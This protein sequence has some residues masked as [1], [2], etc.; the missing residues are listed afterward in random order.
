[1]PIPKYLHQKICLHAK[2]KLGIPPYILATWLRSLQHISRLHN[3]FIYP[4]LNCNSFQLINTTST[5]RGTLP[6]PLYI[7][8]N[9][10]LQELSQV[11]LTCFLRNSGMAKNHGILGNYSG[12]NLQSLMWVLMVDDKVVSH[13]HYIMVTV[14]FTKWTMPSCYVH[15]LML[16]HTLRIFWILCSYSAVYGVFQSELRQQAK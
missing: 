5:L 14:V 12:L 16:K 10:L 4:Y 13:I 3:H 2:L 11:V 6:V 9:L 15:A 1:M 7:K 8:T